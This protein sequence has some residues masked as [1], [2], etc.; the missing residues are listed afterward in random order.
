MGIEGGLR[1]GRRRLAGSRNQSRNV[2]ARGGGEEQPR[3]E[4]GARHAR[5]GKRLA[6]GRES[7]RVGGHASSNAASFCA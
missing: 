5:F 6:A 1:K 4:R 2:E 3:V 7:G